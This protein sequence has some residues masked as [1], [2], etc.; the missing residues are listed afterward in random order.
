MHF[1]GDFQFN[2]LREILELTEIKFYRVPLYYSINIQTKNEYCRILPDDTSLRTNDLYIV[3]FI[4]KR[5]NLS[6]VADKVFWRKQ[7]LKISKNHH[8][9]KCYKFFIEHLQDYISVMF[10]H[11]IRII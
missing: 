3:N 6:I 5:K 10:G 2:Y 8:I 11:H 4:K 9:P 1:N 7:N